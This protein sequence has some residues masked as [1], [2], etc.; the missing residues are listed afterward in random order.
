MHF[1]LSYVFFYFEGVTLPKSEPHFEKYVKMIAMK[2]AD[3]ILL[4]EIFSKPT[5]ISQR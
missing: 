1:P 3:N 5:S 2:M 4:I